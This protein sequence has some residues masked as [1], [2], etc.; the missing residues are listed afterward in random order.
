MSF[1]RRGLF[2]RADSPRDIGFRIPFSSSIGD[3]DF[4][5][6]VLLLD[7]AGADEA[8]DITDLS[9][10]AHVDTFI[11]PAQVDVAKQYLDKNSLLTTGSGAQRLL[12]GGATTDWDF[13]TGDFTV[14]VGYRP[15]ALTDNQGIIGN[16]DNAL[17][18]GWLLQFSKSTPTTLKWYNFSVLLSEDWSPT[19]DVF[20]HV[21]ICRSGTNLRVFL[22]G[23]QLGSTVTDSSDYSGSGQALVIGN[24]ASFLTQAV[25]GSIGAVR[26][27]KGVARYTGNF[28]PPTVFYPTS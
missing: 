1:A 28:T 6:V 12:F 2:A 23:T 3:P 17:S 7:F 21:A 13:G 4:T 10:S 14:E 8:T 25:D 22:D 24:I 20:V 11:S 5:S 9:D 27:T 15:E 18:E 19:L 16:F 26:I